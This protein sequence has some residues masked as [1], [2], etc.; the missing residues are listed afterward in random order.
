MAGLTVCLTH[1]VD[2]I[3]KTYQ[4]LTKDIRS[5]RWGNFRTLLNGAKP[6]WCFDRIMELEASYGVRS[7]FF[8]LHETIPFDLLKPANWKL[9]LGRYSFLETEVKR[10]IRELD[11]GGWEIGLHGSYNSYRNLDLL[12]VEKELLEEVLG[13]EIAGIRQHYLNLDI[14]ETWQLQ[15]KAGFQYDAS[16]GLKNDIGFRQG[17]YRPFQDE[18][19]GITVIPLVLMEAYLFAKARDDLER[20]WELAE[21]L[22]DE[23]EQQQGVF[24]ILWHQRMFNE[25]EFPGYLEIYRRIIEEAKKR[26]ARFFTCREL[27]EEKDEWKED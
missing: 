24:T 19:S 2:R 26:Q 12:Q 15:S 9:T 17:Q 25:Q 5:F 11:Q 1:D 21:A 10:I 14:P 3:R 4:Y 7:T 16:F 23:A 6:Y 20:A 27:H 8:F 13:R 22:M 18:S